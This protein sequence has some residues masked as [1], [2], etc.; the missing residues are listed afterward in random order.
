MRQPNL[1]ITAVV[2]VLALVVA[3]FAGAFLLPTTSTSD[4]ARL[5]AAAAHTIDAPSYRLIGA[6]NTEVATVEAY[7][8]PDRVRMTAPPRLGS[9]PFDSRVIGTSSYFQVSCTAGTVHESGWQR[10]EMAKPYVG[11]P[12]AL[13]TA[14]LI[15]GATDVHNVAHTPN[16]DRYTFI[17]PAISGPQ[18]LDTSLSRGTATVEHGRLAAVRYHVHAKYRGKTYDADSTVTFSRYRTVS[19]IEPPRADQM[20]NTSSLCGGLISGTIGPNPSD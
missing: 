17:P 9:L 6:T 12:T 5:R 20:V 2:V 14:S 13:M 18:G 1:R 7:I 8:A 16:A 10:Q 3:A 19:P 15:D 11:A 4:A